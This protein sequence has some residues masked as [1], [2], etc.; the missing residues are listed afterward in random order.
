MKADI[1]R[2][3][4]QQESLRSEVQSLTKSILELQKQ[5][6]E[7]RQATETATFEIKTRE[8]E[9]EDNKRRME[10]LSKENHQLIKRIMDMKESE[11]SELNK[12]NDVYKTVVESAKTAEME[13]QSRLETIKRQAARVAKQA[14]TT[15]AMTT[16]ENVRN[17][18]LLFWTAYF[19]NSRLSANFP[20]LFNYQ[21]VSY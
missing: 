3:K 6:E 19:E 12:M 20:T 21:Y 1:E 4:E 11:A 10:V 16:T 17:G 2:G 7:E 8:S 5:L 13:A 14:S 9:Y 15:G 18:A